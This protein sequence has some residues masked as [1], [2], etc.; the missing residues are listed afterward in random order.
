MPYHLDMPQLGQY[1]RRV[2][3]FVSGWQVVVCLL[4]CFWALSSAAAPARQ[5]EIFYYVPADD[6]WASFS[7]HVNQIS[8]LAPQVFLIDESGAVHGAV[9]ERVRTLAQQHKVR[10]MPLLFNEKPEAAHAMLSEPKRRRQAVADCL[11]LCEENGCRGLQVDLE[12]V[13]LPDKDNFTEFVREISKAFRARHLQISV[14]VPTPL[15]QPS[16]GFTYPETFGG[17]A[18]IAQPYDLRALAKLVDF[19]TLM[20]Y[21]QYG[22]GTA[23]GPIAG[24]S[25]VEQSIQYALQFVPAGKLSLGLGLWAYRWCNQ[26]V[27]HSGVVEAEELARKNGASP[28]WN[29][30]HRSPWFEFDGD[31]CHNVIWYENQRSLREKLKLVRRYHLYGFSAWRLG[32]EDPDLWRLLR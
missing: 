9:E 15:L 20:T 17:F 6:A 3:D 13:A 26:Q 31:N 21:G 10:L 23:P 5:N 28:Q 11:R 19:V 18:V 25:W 4:L 1:E 29:A 8:V 7:S 16:P 27:S 2:Q 30:W 14:A 32:Q 12:D 24:Y 22:V